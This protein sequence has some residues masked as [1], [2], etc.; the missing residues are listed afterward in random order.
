MPDGC[1]DL[2]HLAA[3]GIHVQ[4]KRRDHV[5]DSLDRSIQIIVGF[6]ARGIV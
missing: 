3:P 2:V 5:T 4:A 6:L 1:E